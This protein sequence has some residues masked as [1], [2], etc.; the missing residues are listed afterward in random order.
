MNIPTSRD[1]LHPMLQ[2][3]QEHPRLAESELHRFL[4]FQFGAYEGGP[5]IAKPGDLR[6]FGCRV[7]VARRA[8][9]RHGM[10]ASGAGD[11]LTITPQGEAYL[12]TGWLRTDGATEPAPLSEAATV[13]VSRASA[14]SPTCFD[15][16]KDVPNP[17]ADDDEPEFDVKA[18]LDEAQFQSND[19]GDGWYQV[20]FLADLRTWNIN[21]R[22][23]R[24][25]LSLSTHVM[26]LPKSRGA[27]AIILDAMARLNCKVPAAKFSSTPRGNVLLELQYRTEH[28]DAEVLGNLIRMLL[29][30]AEDEYPSLLR[31]VVGNPT[32]E[33]LDAAFK[34]SK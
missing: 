10:L 4:A 23:S 15:Q 11:T 30:I 8:L 17:P 27:R 29:Q 12:T 3:A 1:L 14:E 20:I 7:R 13:P 19:L 24:G 33:N 28:A 2:A 34:R 22:A 5:A 21:V 25:W 18:L 32:L 26:R 9:L 6:R 31:V 16:V